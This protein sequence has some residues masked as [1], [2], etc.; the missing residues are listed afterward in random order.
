MARGVGG[1]RTMTGP[2]RILL[3]S[4]EEI[5]CPKAATVRSPVKDS[6]FSIVFDDVNC[7]TD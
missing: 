6:I 7:F 2:T 1:R 3:T 4:Y 5:G